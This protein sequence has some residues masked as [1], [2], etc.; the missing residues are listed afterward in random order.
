MLGRLAGKNPTLGYC[1][2]LNFL[3]G[4]L[5]LV[6]GGSECEAFYMLEVLL[7]EYQLIGFYTEEMSYLKRS[8][9]VFS[10]LF[11]KTHPRLALHFE[12]QGVINEMWILQ[13][14]LTLF[15]TVL[16]FDVVA[17][18]WDIFLVDR[19]AILYQVSLAILARFEKDLLVLETSE[20][21]E[22]LKSLKDSI[23]S[24]EK[25]ISEAQ[26]IDLSY[27]SVKKMERKYD[28]STSIENIS[29][30]EMTKTLDPPAYSGL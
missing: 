2:S 18:I 26:K 29:I 22:F 24:P 12:E 20:I 23:H 11:A 25:L 6:N 3:S 9:W 28:Q 19:I 10:Q 8:M 1:Q 7:H 17:R 30:C 5:L 21:C 13:W 4:F 16:S 14:F 27:L 15:T